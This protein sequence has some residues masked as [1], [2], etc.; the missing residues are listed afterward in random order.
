MSNIITTMTEAKNPDTVV[1]AMK[2]A[3]TEA[4]HLIDNTR[5]KKPAKLD[6][7]NNAMGEAHKKS[8]N[9][10]S[11]AKERDGK[12]PTNATAERKGTLNQATIAENRNQG[13]KSRD[14]QTQD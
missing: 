9:C 8:L 11:N 5:T 3:R 4:R 10:I 1:T 2:I 14:P 6:G 7:I 12:T 13:G